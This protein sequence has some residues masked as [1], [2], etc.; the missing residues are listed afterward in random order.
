[1]TSDATARAR[2]TE[3]LR[4]RLPDA[5]ALRRRLHAEP[6]L[7]G[8][9]GQTRDTVIEALPARCDV[10]KTAD[11][12]AV[13]RI[14]G[15]GPA[16]AV[17]GEMD[18]LAVTE[19]TGTPWASRRTGVMHACGHDVHMAAATALALA[20]DQVDGAVPMLMVLQPREEAYPS[21]ALDIVEDGVL[22]REQCR[23]VIGAHVQPLLAPGTVACT[24]GAVNASSD[25]FTLTVHGQ[26]G[27]AAY[28]HLTHDPVAALAHIVVALQTL[29]SRRTDPMSPLVLSVTRLDAGSASNVV[30]DVA[31]ARGTLR[32]MDTGQRAAVQR[33]MR[34]TAR[35]VARTQGCRA[36][37][38]FVH[39]EPVLVNDP[40]LTSATAPLLA[41]LGLRPAPELRS[42]GSDDFSYYSAHFPSLMMF[43]GTGGGGTRG[44][45]TG[46]DE[47]RLHS[48]AFLPDDTAVG[49]VAH[50][51][52]A[53]YLAAAGSLLD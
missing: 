30:P 11:T 51:L 31:S 32:A 50:A 36:E 5:I 53:G 10:A 1:M 41:E 3:E 49:E 15:A 20:V 38:T 26:G 13:V 47:E 24:P 19:R 9:E 39:G 21:G 29:V 12:G 44:D 16:I 37:V 43:V 22:R 48:A 46:G 25:E 42:A 27:H 14:G 8:D 33:E 2:L 34:E 52:L 7:S 17:R 18:A 6:R 4:R 28:P 23:A 45:G 40:A 35:L